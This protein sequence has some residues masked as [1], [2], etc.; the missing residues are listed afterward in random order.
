MTARRLLCLLCALVALTAAATTPEVP[1]DTS[2]TV[3]STARKVHKKHP[4]AVLARPALPQ[5]VREDRDAVYSTLPDTPFGRRDLHADIFR[6]DN[7]SVYPALI[8]IHGGGWNSGDKSLQVP[9]AQRIAARGYVTIP[10]EYRLIPE[11]LYPAGLHD[12]KG[13]V[14]WARD[15]AARYGI[16]PHRIAVSGCSAGAQLATLV[17][18]TNGSRSHEGPCG[19]NPA[20]SHV[21]AVINIDGIATFV[22]ES[23]IADARARFES[24]GVLPVNAQWLGG[25]YEDAPDNWRHASAL[26]WI[27]R[28]SAPVCFIS[29][30]LPRYSD[31]RDELVARYDM[32]GIYTERHSIP[33]D[34]HPFW[35]FHP[36]VDTTV[37]HAV[38]FLDRIFK[39]EKAVVPA[40]P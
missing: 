9:M 32:L 39:P 35:F 17:G 3:W 4:E 31:G 40:L 14:R 21:Q 26:L 36:W 34:V 29:S 6:P 7:D 22:S 37:D 13:A 25:L 23:N 16:D 1:R 11:A 38:R 20:S 2:F 5:G 24:K 19:D 8:M 30:G 18:V 15:N 27:T 28:Q 33:V 10:V 12:I